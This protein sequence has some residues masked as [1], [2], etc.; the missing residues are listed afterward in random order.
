MKYMHIKAA[1]GVI[2]IAWEKES[3]VFYRAGVSF[4]SPRDHWDRKKGNLIA[5]WRARKMTGNNWAFVVSDETAQGIVD[6]FNNIPF[7]F[8]PRWLKQYDK[9]R[10]E[11]VPVGAAMLNPKT[12]ILEHRTRPEFV[13]QKG[14][15]Q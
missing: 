1:G 10:L 13:F 5:A 2:T 15:C 3:G 4:C 9:A 14:G 12:G 6:G 7:R 11:M 8:R